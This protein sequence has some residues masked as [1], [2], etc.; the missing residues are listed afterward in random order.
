MPCTARLI[1]ASFTALLLVAIAL[2][3][4]TQTSRAQEPEWRVGLAEV[5]ITPDKPV[6]MSGYA[7]RNKPHESIEHDLH[8]K[9]LALVDRRGERAVLVTCDL[10]LFQPA[11]IEPVCKRIA[12]QTGLERSR[13]VFNA[14]HTHTGPALA[15]E[16]AEGKA[17]DPAARNTV[18]YTR[19]L[20]DRLVEVVVKALEKPEPARLSWGTGVATFVMNRRE[21]TEQG[22][23]LGVNPRG[24]VDRS[25]PLIRID[26]PD[27]K[28]RAVWFGCACHNTTLGGDIYQICGDYAGFAQLQIEQRYPGIQAMFMQN[29]G[30][31]ANPYPRSTMEIARLHGRTLGEEVCRVMETKLTEVHGPLTVKFNVLQVPLQPIP[32]REKLNQMASRRS[33]WEPEIAKRMLARLD[34]GESGP[35]HFAYPVSAWQFGDSLTWIGLSGE[36]VVD[37]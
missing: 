14:S 3:F 18:E 7:S 13:I 24:V 9:A 36:V 23:K 5:K 10:C 4:D 27:G 11:V 17:D 31:D 6:Y 1:A 12:E 15:A 21:F 28:P 32:P 29:T 30:G 34:R 26:S 22:V 35:S 25:V 19:W 37:Y 16:L 8:A 2:G 20:Q 33:G